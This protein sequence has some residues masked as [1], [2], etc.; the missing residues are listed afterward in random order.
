MLQVQMQGFGSPEI[1]KVIDVATPAPGKGQVLIKSVAAGVNRPDCLQRQGLYKP[2]ADA[3]PVL[4]LEVA[5]EVV[6]LGAG[7]P[8]S[9]LKQKVCALVHGGGYSEYVVAESSLCL[10]YPRGLSGEEAACLPE[11]FFTVWYNMFMRAGLKKGETLLVHGGSSGIGTTAIQLAKCFGVTVFT[12]VSNEQK[13]Q[14]CYELGADFVI[15]YNNDDFV[16]RVKLETKKR[17]VDVILDMVG[18]DY[19]NRN[20]KCLADQGRLSQIA[21]LQGSRAEVDLMSVMTKR[22]QISG[23]TM[24]ARTLAEKT[25]IASML[26]QE[27]WPLLASGAIAPVMDEQFSLEQVSQAHM[28]MEASNHIGKIALVLQ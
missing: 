4:G 7:C 22:L 11:T 8:S 27:I 18:G 15:N 3:S 13:A 5:G 6:E 14:K 16:E 1:L 26:K 9:F 21:F 24:R 2:P 28:K 20:I 17:G 12:T 10:P 25:V 23:S 19:I